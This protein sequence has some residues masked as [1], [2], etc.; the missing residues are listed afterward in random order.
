MH[1]TPLHVKSPQCKLVCVVKENSR[2]LGLEAQ[3][4][5]SWELARTKQVLRAVVAA[6]NQRGLTTAQ[7]AELCSAFSGEDIKTATLNGLF[8]GKRKSLSINELVM[9]AT[10]LRVPI[11]DLLFPAREDIRLDANRTMQSSSAVAASMGW[12]S[13]NL[14]ADRAS[15][16]FLTGMA[17]ELVAMDAQ[18]AIEAYRTYGRGGEAV[19]ALEKLRASVRNLRRNMAK[20]AENN[21]GEPPHLRRHVNWVRGVEGDDLT[22]EM[23]PGIE[24]AM[25]EAVE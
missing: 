9:F 22:F 18:A 3:G 8:A 14:G 1:C 10:V 4:E 12:F 11:L 24:E 2:K 23:L 17:V 21:W 20:F 15:V 25:K 19:I 13:P 7:L 16:I 6:K 5:D